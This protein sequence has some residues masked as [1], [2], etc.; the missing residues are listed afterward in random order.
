MH[1]EILRELITYD[2]ETLGVKSRENSRLEFKESFSLGSRTKYAK[3]MMAFANA[4]GGYI[5]F[6]ISDN[7]RIVKGLQDDRFE[8]LD[9]RKLTEFLN[10]HCSPEIIWE[11]GSIEIE[12]KA[13]GF[14]FVKEAPQ[15]PLICTGNA[16][17]N[18]IIEGRVYYRYRG[19]SLEIKYSELRQIIEDRLELERRAWMKH[20]EKIA[21][22]G[23]T[24]VG[25]LDTIEGKIHGAGKP[26]LIAPN[27][28]DKLKFIREGTFT[29]TG[30]DPTLTLIGDVST[31]GPV[32][33]IQEVPQA[34][35]YEEIIIHFL[36]NVQ[37][38][39]HVA[40]AYLEECF[41][42][43]SHYMPIHHYMELSNTSLQEALEMNDQSPRS[44]LQK[45]RFRDRIE[46]N[47]NIPPV[48]VFDD[49][50]PEIENPQEF[51]NIYEDSNSQKRKRS[52]LL[53]V[54]IESPQNILN[55]LASIDLA[56]L[57]EAFTALEEERIVRTEDLL[58]S[59]LLDVFQNYFLDLESPEKTLFRKATAKID[60]TL[61]T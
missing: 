46:R 59:I 4:K 15:K 61:N 44:N 52:V 18:D 17:Q 8:R 24:N 35:H 23:P 48:A 31:T 34:I 21:T 40:S 19:Q 22:A 43:N 29:D 60:E 49:P 41:R 27:L 57:F 6:G 58:K 54:L 51:L 7:P 1:E 9:P 28:L 32:I 10:Q 50:L 16:G 3:T 45:Q 33:G 39:P 38:R 20:I 56:R 55:N 14:I 30:G 2:E 36:Q 26:F 5:A 13:I 25:I 12:N 53:K 37:M 11:P 47:Q 42:Q